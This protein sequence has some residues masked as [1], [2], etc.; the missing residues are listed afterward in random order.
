MS[1]SVSQHRTVQ[2]HSK[3][4]F[5]SY[6]DDSQHGDEANV[7]FSELGVP[8]M[9]CRALASEGKATA[10]PI[11]KDTLPDSLAGRDILGRGKTGSGKTLAFAIPL[12]VRL[13]MQGGA[14]DDETLGRYE[15]AMRKRGGQF[16]D[17]G[18]NGRNRGGSRR[19]GRNQRNMP[20][21]EP[22]GLIL[23]PT[24]ELANQINEVV[25]PLA[26]LCRLQTTTVY[27]GVR[28]QRQV[29]ALRAGADIVVAC[30]GRLEDLLRQRLLSLDAVE[31]TILD[32]ADEM[33]DMGFLP[34]VERL[35]EQIPVEAQH[36][37]F[38]A[39][40]DHGIDE[41]VHRFLHN[42]KVHEIDDATAHVSTMTHHIFETT[43]ATKH[44]LVR[45][46]ASGKGKR[47]LFTRTKYQAKKLAKNL[48]N[49]GI[50]AAELHGNLS[51]NQR[52]R[53]LN[54]FSN[55]S[56]KVLV[57]TDV[58][59]RGVDVSGV[60]LVVQ[61]DPPAD[62]KSFLH[63]SGRTAR[64]GHEGDVVTLVLPEQ[65]RDVRRMLRIA[66][67]TSK[68]ISVTSDSPAVESLVGQHAERIDGWTLEPLE[69]VHGSGSHRHGGR[70][71]RSG[72][73]H[74]G[75]NGSSSRPG[76]RGENSRSRR[77]EH[78]HNSE[79]S[80]MRGN[81]SRGSAPRRHAKKNRA[82]FRISG[83]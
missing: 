20:L 63:R 23:A 10:F 5:K 4:D 16:E 83:R 38:S 28:Q 75:Q 31:V 36:M 22:R 73:R 59:A 11:Q 37:L 8:E 26:A 70:G 68:P 50:P 3:Q 40:L 12:I 27:G 46:L 53:N 60:E 56:V 66:N 29:D 9:I 78:Q 18:R 13:G 45:T 48:T 74:G 79:R 17:E 55:G 61:V 64:A 34:A 24:R 54:A 67:I 30:P 81:D 19:S 71:E 7:P 39:T 15:R 47:I 33:A 25:E 2:T 62:A 76:S 43:Q 57:A 77:S 21:P 14:E 42:P 49:S 65:R 69:P 58:A 32:E 6:E 41:L 35:L 82:P 44:E 51:Q 72:R 52:D 80:S 1:T